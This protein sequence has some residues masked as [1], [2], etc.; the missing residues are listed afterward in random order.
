MCPENDNGHV[1][2]ETHAANDDGR[3]LEAFMERSVKLLRALTKRRAPANGSVSLVSR[4]R[5][6]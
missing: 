5:R 2:A 3:L 4:W 6:A 1:V